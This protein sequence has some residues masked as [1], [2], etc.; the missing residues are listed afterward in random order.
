MRIY[1]CSGNKTVP[2]A[3]ELKQGRK[4]RNLS[5]AEAGFQSL[6]FQLRSRRT[7]IIGIYKMLTI[8]PSY[9]KPQEFH[10]W[11]LGAIAPRPIAFA[12]TVNKKGEVN[13]SPFSF[14]NAFGSNPPLVVFSPSLRGRDGT[15]KHTLENVREVDEVVINIV[16]YAMVQQTSLASTEYP[17]GVNEFIKSGFTQEPS[18]KVK[19]P[20]VK[21]SPA[22][23]ECKVK[24][25]IQTGV[26]GG[27]A[28]LI[29]C[30]IVLMH[31]SE[32]V[33]DENGRIDPVKIDQVARMGGDWYTRAAKGVFKVPKP[34]TTH[35]MGVDELPEEIR[36]SNVLTGND[37]GMLGNTEEFPSESMMTEYRNREDVKKFFNEISKEATNSTM[38]VHLAAHH[39]LSESK[40]NEAWMLLL[41]HH[42]N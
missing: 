8:N 38:A 16:N 39:L 40:V 26:Y 13:L 20:R 4:N 22:Q 28:N 42:K 29:I 9:L 23:L 3:E 11:M 17:K 35:G 19:P 2:S 1:G 12:S 30:E 18:V 37:L 6:N 34:L 27:A 15:I 36:L 7:I 10:A 21:E 41:T 24:Q 33:L 14:F 31:V 25:I 32:D 5:G